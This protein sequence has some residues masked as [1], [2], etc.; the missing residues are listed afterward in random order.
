MRVAAGSALAAARS[1]A[2]ISWRV[3]MA[4]K[5]PRFDGQSWRMPVTSALNRFVDAKLLSESG[6]RNQAP[7]DDRSAVLPVRRESHPTDW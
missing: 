6:G 4:L 1:I 7:H 2:Q 3:D 5:H